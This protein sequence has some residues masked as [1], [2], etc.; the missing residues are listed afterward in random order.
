MTP[1]VGR[2]V[3]YRM[4]DDDVT[5]ARQELRH[6]VRMEE[7]NAPQTGQTYAAVITS[8]NGHLDHPDINLR[9]LLD[10]PFDFFAPS[11]AEGA[12]PGM[13]SWPERVQ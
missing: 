13:W 9:V 11:R 4:S 6:K 3:H 2:I 10:G 7:H 12:E 8:V 5:R 1:T